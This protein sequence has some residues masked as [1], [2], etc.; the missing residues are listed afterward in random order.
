MAIL[1][2]SAIG[3]VNFSGQDLLADVFSVRGVQPVA[4]LSGDAQ[5]RGY[6]LIEVPLHV[7]LKILWVGLWKQSSLPVQTFVHMEY[8]KPGQIDL[9]TVDEVGKRLV[10]AKW[11]TGQNNIRDA[12]SFIVSL[13]DLHKLACH[14]LAHRGGI[15]AHPERNLFLW[16]LLQF[17]VWNPA[18]CENIFRSNV[19]GHRCCSGGDVIVVGAHLTIAS[20]HQT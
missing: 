16:M 4:V 18:P 9:F 10:P 12:V 15:L 19:G 6:W 2:P 3:D 20:F 11:S 5:L 17:R 1:P 8:D 7:V 14:D 13:Y